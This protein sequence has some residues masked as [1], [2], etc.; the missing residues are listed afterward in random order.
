S[1]AVEEQFYLLYPLILTAPFASGIRKRPMTAFAVIGAI[2]IAICV[3]GD[4]RHSVGAFYLMPARAWELMFGSM[5]AVAPR[6]WLD[7]LRWSDGVAVLSLSVILGSFWLF[8]DSTGFPSPFVIVPCAA[9]A[10]LLG[11]G[12]QHSATVLRLLSLR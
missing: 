1:L 2:S 9:T 8:D 7:R 10:L 12:R 3:R 11:V 5:A 6:S 4:L